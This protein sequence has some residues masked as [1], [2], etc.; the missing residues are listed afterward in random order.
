MGSIIY[1]SLLSSIPT[2]VALLFAIIAANYIFAVIELV[3]GSLK[4]KKEFIK[5]MNP[6]YIVIL[7]VKTVIA[8]WKKLK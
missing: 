3:A 8:E 2:M 4:T 5:R 1:L 6:F 7:T